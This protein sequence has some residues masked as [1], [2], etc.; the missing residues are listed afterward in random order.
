[1]T[2]DWFHLRRQAQ[3]HAL[4]AQLG[5]QSLDIDRARRDNPRWPASAAA[6]PAA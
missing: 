6:A 1:M 3:E 4:A 5:L 2:G